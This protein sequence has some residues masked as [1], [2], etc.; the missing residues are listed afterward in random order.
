MAKTGPTKSPFPDIAKLIEQFKV[1]GL[2][3][4]RIVEAQRKNIEALTQANQ[5]AYEG[6]QDLAKRQMEILQ[7]TVTEWQAA[8]TEAA[9]REGT[10]T[11]QRAET[12][13]K[14]FGK[15]F[16]NMRELAE[17]A[18]KAQTQAWEVIQKRFQENLADL[19]NLLRP[20]K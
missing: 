20:P 5:A 2:D 16:A 3:V 7:E 8:M 4:S 18:A 1:P 19:R 12:A 13:E 10:N 6:M 17:M 15:A 11:A 9:N 14:T